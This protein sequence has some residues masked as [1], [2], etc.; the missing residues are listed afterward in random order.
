MGVRK[1]NGIKL[2]WT[3]ALALLAAI[4]FQNEV[5]AATTTQE[6]FDNPRLYSDIK[7]L[8]N[9]TDAFK[10]KLEMIAQAKQKIDMVYFIWE[11]DYTSS[12]LM[13]KLMLRA[14]EGIKI[15][16]LVDYM[17]TEAQVAALLTLANHLSSGGRHNIEVKRFRPPT[18]LLMKL[19]K[20]D[21]IDSFKFI[22]GLMILDKKAQQDI[23]ESLD[24]SKIK[25][26]IDDF[27][28]KHNPDFPLLF[29]FVMD[30]LKHKFPLLADQL[31]DFLKR[32]HYKLL[33]IDD[34]RFIVGGRNI[35]DQYHT[36]GLSTFLQQTE[37]NGPRYTFQDTEVEATEGKQTT[38]QSSQREAFYRLWTFKDSVGVTDGS[39]YYDEKGQTLPAPRLEQTIFDRAWKA[40]LLG[41]DDGIFSSSTLNL[42][43]PL[44]GQ[45]F[46]NGASSMILT[47]MWVDEGRLYNRVVLGRE[48]AREYVKLIQAAKNRIDIVTAYFYIDN[49]FTDQDYN[50]IYEAL[51]EKAKEGI[52]VTVYTN[53]PLSTDLAI[54]NYMSYR[55][56]DQ[57]KKDGI[58]V[59]ELAPEQGSLHTKVMAIDDNII[60]VGSF[61]LD[62]RSQ[63]YDTNDIL[64]LEDDSQTLVRH[65]RAER[66]VPNDLNH[67]ESEINS[68]QGLKWVLPAESVINGKKLNLHEY[69]EKLKPVINQLRRSI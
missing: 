27:R 33:L 7:L 52:K 38:N 25:G 64:V 51:K 56:Y 43:G 6:I 3:W 13:Q 15:R 66:G 32:S 41:Y 14:D 30:L 18:D 37:I 49:G 23:L 44:Q 57:L 17:E 54:V 24:H 65:F 4:I 67:F 31:N 22:H 26:D 53:S 40:H 50:A 47:P 61:N 2:I 28:T 29:S 55:N 20:D 8:T 45:I 35:S 48:I 69:E 16:I 62:P 11:E 5:Y 39:R 21:G 60:A 34:I 63:I 46:E 59:Y 36:E 10:A 12:L 9:N 1:I 58:T 68:G 42:P 19:L